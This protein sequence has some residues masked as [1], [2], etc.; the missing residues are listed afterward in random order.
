MFIPL[1]LLAVWVVA[2][3]V[4]MAICRTAAC[5]DRAPSAVKRSRER[6]REMLGS[7]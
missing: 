4:A 5:G 2:M 1:I 6:S 3:L 7:G